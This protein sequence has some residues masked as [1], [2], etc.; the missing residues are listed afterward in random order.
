[1]PQPTFWQTYFCADV[2]VPSSHL[3]EPYTAKQCWSRGLSGL[4]GDQLAYDSGVLDG[5]HT[6]VPEEALAVP[7]THTYLPAAAVR[8]SSFCAAECTVA[9]C[10]LLALH[11]ASASAQESASVLSV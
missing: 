3:P 1:M 11:E 5:P 7:P 8:S 6:H 4:P 10:W 2:Q 9:S